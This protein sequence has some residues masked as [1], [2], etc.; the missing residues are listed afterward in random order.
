MQGALLTMDV[1]SGHVLAMVGGYDF[2]KSQFNRADPGATPAWVVLQAVA[3]CGG[4]GRRH[5]A[6]FDGPGRTAHEQ[7][8][9]WRE[10]LAPGELR[11]ASTMV[12]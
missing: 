8:R 11:M 10:R 6:G 4:P 1:G 2:M 9:C 12:R 7:R 5:D 3:L